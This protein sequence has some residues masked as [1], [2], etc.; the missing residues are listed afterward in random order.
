MLVQTFVPPRGFVPPRLGGAGL[1]RVNQ[2]GSFGRGGKIS[3]TWRSL[4]PLSR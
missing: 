3:M 1:L 4:A 2:S